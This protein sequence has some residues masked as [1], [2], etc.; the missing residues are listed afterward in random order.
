MIKSLT[1]TS[2]FC[3]LIICV[4]VYMQS[5]QKPEKTAD[6]TELASFDLIQDRI[7]TKTCATSGCHASESDGAFK[8][9]GLVLA[10]GVAYKNLVSVAPKNEEAKAGGLMRVKPFQSEL[11]LLYHKLEPNSSLHHAGKN[12]GSIMPLGS[13][14]L[15]AGEIEF[16]RRWIEAGAP[17]KGSVVDVKL[18]DDKTP[19]LVA[20]FEPLAP[21]KA[22]EGYQVKID[23]FTI[24]PNFE[25]E[26]FV[27]RAIGNS[28]EIYVNRLVLRA[29]PNSHHMVLYDFRDRNLL[30]AMDVVRDLRNANN[31]LNLQTVYEMSNHIFLG[32]G[33][34]ANQDYV[35]PEGSAIKLPANYSIDLN[36]HYF[37][38]TAGVLYGENYINL[39]TTEKSKVQHVVKMLDLQNQQLELP[40]KTRKTFTKSWTFDKTTHVVMLTSHNHK[41]GEK[42]IIKIKGGSR[43]GQVVY[44]STDWEHPLVKNFTPPIELVKG[45]G[46]TSEITYYNSG[47][48]AIRFGLTSDDEM[49]IIF[50]YYYED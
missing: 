28:S 37:N 47:D 35:L 5:C 9:H 11:S 25:R 7:L 22:S 12:Y 31:T 10:K 13:D 4:C 8:Q 15:F 41:M 24:N 48:V 18:L 36:A 33:T 23:L 32:G 3:F 38:K 46:L 39:Y 14:P 20:A 40:A 43:D 50:G 26:V 29:R 1:K 16:V 30:P 49:G 21:P 45:E 44:E 42:F 34:L 19:S 17:E 27:R 6:P 2:S